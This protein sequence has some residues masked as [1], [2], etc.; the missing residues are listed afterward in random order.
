MPAANRILVPLGLSAIGEAKLPLVEQQARALDA[1]VILLHVLEH[2]APG[3]TGH[4]SPQEARARAYLDSMAARVRRAGVPA[5]PLVRRG[6]VASAVRDAAREQ[7]ASLI[8]V[9]DTA[10]AGL[11][12]FL[13]RGHAQAIAREAPCP[14]LLVP[15]PARG[16]APETPALR[17]FEDDAQR[18]G[19]VAP[20]F[21]GT[22][23]VERTRIVGTV[24]PAPALDITFRPRRP[25]PRER[26]HFQNILDTFD[27]RPMGVPPLELYK[28]G[29]GYYVLG[30]H[31]RVAAAIHLGQAW[32][33]AVVTEYVPRADEHAQRVLAEREEFERTTG[34]TR[35]GAARPGTYPRL[36]ALIRAGGLRHGIDDPYRAAARWYASVFRPLQI[37]LRAFHLAQHFPGERS[38]DILLRV[39]HH[40]WR[41]SARTQ[42]ELTWEE[43]LQSF[44]Q[45]QRSKE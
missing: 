44:V 21:R 31:L 17:C 40:L 37:R 1:E 38:A 10:R 22:R 14:V 19:P 28:L 42:Q 39:S 7:E 2:A 25:S 33:E 6:Q 29:Y 12:G 5:Q 35:V 11:T 16:P 43:A 4:V 9:G 27:R 30:G 20:Y 15:P 26:A 41:E 13:R 24:A 32:I 36:E 3:E 8:V 18:A 23:T 45:A 34:L